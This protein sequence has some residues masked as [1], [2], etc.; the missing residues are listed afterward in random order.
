MMKAYLYDLA[1]KTFVCSAKYPTSISKAVRQLAGIE[2][3]VVTDDSLE[4]FDHPHL[5][6]ENRAVEHQ[7]TS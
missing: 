4:G 5:N 6:F 1:T 7:T 2:Y 3:R